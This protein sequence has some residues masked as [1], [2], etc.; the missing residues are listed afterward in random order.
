[1]EFYHLLLPNLIK[2]W[3]NKP[4]NSSEPSQQSHIPSLTREER[5]F[6]PLKAVF[7]QKK[8]PFEHAAVPFKG[9]KEQKKSNS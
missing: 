8:N 6:T 5:M 4:L 9:E 7:S 3:E 1:M 2:R